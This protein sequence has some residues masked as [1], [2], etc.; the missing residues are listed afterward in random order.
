MQ[1]YIVLLLVAAASA[2]PV[3]TNLLKHKPNNAPVLNL[4]HENVHIT[5]QVP[6]VAPQVYTTLNKQVI[7]QVYTTLNKQVIPQVYTTLNKQVVPQVY[8]TLNKQVVPQVYSTLNKQVVPQ[9]YS[10]LNKQVVPQVYST[11]SKQV[12]PQVYTTKMNHQV[13]PQVY[14]TLNKQ[15]VPQVYSHVQS[16]N[17]PLIHTPIYQTPF[18][19]TPVFKT[20]ET[21]NLVNAAIQTPVVYSVPQQLTVAQE[22]ELTKGYVAATHGSL[23]TAPLPEGPS[24]DGYFA[25]HHINLPTA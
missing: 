24:G 1:A 5:Q 3:T 20:V 19:Q 13:I 8:S 21:E 22:T 6:V 2:N 10:T 16:I 12:V 9:V 17:T 15:V 4:N 23:H 7:P 25:S 18:I 11:Q 14:T